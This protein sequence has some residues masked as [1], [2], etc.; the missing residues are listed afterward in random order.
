MEAAIGAA[1]WL[2]GKLLNKLSDDLVA[3][4]V[5]SSDLGLN[6]ENLKTKLRYMQG[7]LHTAQERDVS[8]N[9]G[10]QEGR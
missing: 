9:P 1:N 5:A 2:V 6:S 4:Y 3:P 10:L 8:S 7:L